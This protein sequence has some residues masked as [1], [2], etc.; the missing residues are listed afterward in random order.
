MP[1]SAAAQGVNSSSIARDSTPRSPQS[2]AGGRGRVPRRGGQ[3]LVC[4]APRDGAVSRKEDVM[5]AR[6]ISLEGRVALV[7]GAARGIGQAIA[8]T[9]AEWGADVAIGDVRLAKY[10]GDAYYTARRW[11]R[12][13][14]DVP[15]VE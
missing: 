13:D 14:E 4:A 10:T 1:A 7:T 3:A 2:E 12:E 11:S 15:T 8:L 5:A 9:L 6:D